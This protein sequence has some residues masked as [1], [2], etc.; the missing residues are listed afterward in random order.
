MAGCGLGNW[1]SIPGRDDISSSQPLPDQ[2]PF[3]YA[4]EF[5]SGCIWPEREAEHSPPSSLEVKDSWNYL[6]SASVFIVVHEH[7]GNFLFYLQN[8][9]QIRFRD[10]MIK[11]EIFSKEN[12]VK[13]NQLHLIES[14][15]L[16]YEH[17]F[18]PAIKTC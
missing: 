5:I 12:L 18:L 6:L 2:P 3:Q 10:E 15:I 7:R 9:N 17:E 1:G 11:A 4:P 8:P 14:V 16:L 13:S